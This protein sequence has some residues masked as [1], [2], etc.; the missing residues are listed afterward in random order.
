[1]QI[2][3]SVL[4]CLLGMLFG[5][6]VLV[7]DLGI[8]KVHIKTKLNHAAPIM[9]GC[10]AWASAAYVFYIRGIDSVIDIPRVLMLVS[11][12]WLSSQWRNRYINC[13]IDKCKRGDKDG[14]N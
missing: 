8:A 2:T 12:C 14:S 11:W 3:N 7:R 5:L 10:L 1:M 6:F 9:F 13:K 4:L